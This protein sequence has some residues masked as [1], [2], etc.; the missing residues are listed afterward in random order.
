MMKVEITKEALAYLK[1]KDKRVVTVK[2]IKAGG[3]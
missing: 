2:L 3:G 1:K